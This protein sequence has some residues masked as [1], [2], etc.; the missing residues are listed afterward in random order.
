MKVKKFRIKPR[1]PT[2]G[3]ILK[4]LMGVKQ[5]PPEVETSLPDECQKFLPSL[6][7]AVFY[8]TWSKD[9]VPPALQELFGKAQLNKAVA[10]SV[11]AAT[12]GS[13]A[14]EYLST[15]LMDGQTQR[16]QMVTA[17]CE[18]STDLAFQFLEKLLAND[19]ESDGCETTPPLFISDDANL[20]EA[21]NLLET[22][23]EGIQLDSAGHLTPRFT[24]FGVVGW[25]PINK[26]KRSL[27]LSKKSSS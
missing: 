25:H 21:L 19:A 27:S 16:A 18:E 15:L 9:Q 23:P 24:R 14:E 22:G 11:L 4:S 20:G 5:L 1:F 17:F 6:H 2:V 3:K 12:I 13:T 7:P 26:K 8:K 10:V